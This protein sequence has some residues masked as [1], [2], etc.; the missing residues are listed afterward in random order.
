MKGWF[1]PGFWV[2]DKAQLKD[3]FVVYQFL[4]DGKF[5]EVG[6]YSHAK[7]SLA[8]NWPDFLN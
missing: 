1:I 4:F 6:F 8:N 7:G 2:V 5:P 3:L